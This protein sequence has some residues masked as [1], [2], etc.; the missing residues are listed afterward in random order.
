[1]SVFVFSGENFRATK[2]RM[3]EEEMKKGN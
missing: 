3:I 1:M 2:E